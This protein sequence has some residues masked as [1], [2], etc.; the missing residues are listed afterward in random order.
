MTVI[1]YDGRSVAADRQSTN[2]GLRN[3][4][5]KLFK[6]ES[7]AVV[8]VTGDYSLSLELK[9]WFAAGCQQGKCP[10]SRDKDNF[11]KIVVFNIDGRV[12]EYENCA[13]PIEVLD[14]FKAWGCG[15][16]YAIAAMDLGKSAK[17][18]VLLASKYDAFCGLG[19][20]VVDLSAHGEA[21]G[22]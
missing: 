7:G 18:A 12:F 20:D 1:A 6:L 22:K 4:A 13:Q 9:D 14:R 11:G 16:D 21:Y 2:N 15:R 19:V 10:C 17:E 5:Q 8:A 3:E